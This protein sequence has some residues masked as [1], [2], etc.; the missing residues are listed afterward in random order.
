MIFTYI[1][2]FLFVIILTI[3]IL[4]FLSVYVFPRKIEEIQK[5]IEAGQIKLAI[6][7]LNEILE[8]DERNPYAHF[9]LAEAYAADGNTQYAIVE[10][11][12]VLKMGRF[13]DK[14]KEVY[15]RQVLAKLYKE[16]KAFEDAKKEFL[17]LTKIDPANYE[18]FF[19][20]GMIY[21]NMNQM[22]KALNYPKSLL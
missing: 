6:R 22:D 14:I 21:Y 5:M 2:I 20:L 12:Q 9:L 4:Y 10:Y 15:V 11:R 17:I 19:E 16:K 18:N 8:K 13:D 1:L 7:K 3:I